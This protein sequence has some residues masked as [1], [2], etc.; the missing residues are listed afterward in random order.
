[1]IKF[2]PIIPI[3]A[4]E[5][6]YK[7][8]HDMFML[9]PGALA[10]V[11]VDGI[12][13]DV[14]Q[15]FA[16][17][18]GYERDTL[19]GANL[20][21]LTAEPD[22]E[23]SGGYLQQIRTGKIKQYSEEKRCLRSDGSVL[24]VE[25]SA[26]AVLD[27]QG[28]PRYLILAFKNISLRR[29]YMD[30]LT[31]R[32][33]KTQLLLETAAEGFW[34]CDTEEPIENAS[35]IINEGSRH[36][37]RTDSTGHAYLSRMM[38]KQ[39]ADIAIDQGSLED[40]QWIPSLQ[41]MRVLPRPGKVHTVDFPVVMTGEID[42]TVYLVDVDGK[43]RGI[44]NAEIDLV[45]ADGSIVSTVRSANDGYYIIPA[46]RPGSYQVQVSPEQL[47]KLGLGVGEMRQVVMQADGEFISGLGFNIARPAAKQP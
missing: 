10:R 8:Y 41:G 12:L 13:L 21:Q 45:A 40:P 4:A 27:E 32:E 20:M 38:P 39:Y 23:Q 24:W 18:L 46:V 11:S 16:Q 9:S 6:A 19:I 15:A 26:Q 25:A 36:P 37:A 17:M 22:L 29:Q 42:G 34:V 35:F 30:E 47:E 28:A 1:M 31:Q 43:K 7:L 33:R 44:G 2:S 5:A 3:P 14:N